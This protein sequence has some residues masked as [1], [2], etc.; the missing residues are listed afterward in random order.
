M[1]TDGPNGS[2]KRPSNIIRV[3]WWKGSSHAAAELNEAAERRWSRQAWG[4]GITATA[5][6]LVA[7]GAL[8]SYELNRP[9]ADAVIVTGANETRTRIFGDGIHVLLSELSKL[10][11]DAVDACCLVHLFA[12]EA[13]F[14]VPENPTRELVVATE[15]ANAISNAG[16]FSVSTQLGLVVQ[17]QEGSV[18]VARPGKPPVILMKGMRYGLGD[19]MRAAVPG[20]RRRGT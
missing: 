17:V 6:M 10:Q 20:A 3:N 13:R 4:L 19:G 15:F 16:K 8:V 5:A 9:P 18:R 2:G 12:G 14:S 7:V 11:I 1:T